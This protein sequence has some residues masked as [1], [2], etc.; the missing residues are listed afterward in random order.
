MFIK[1]CKKKYALLTLSTHYPAVL[2]KLLL[3]ASFLL[4]YRN[5]ACLPA[6]KWPTA[7]LRYLEKKGKVHAK[8]QGVAVFSLRV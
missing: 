6:A 5:V 8:V 4:L 1:Q 7:S 3:A 2:L